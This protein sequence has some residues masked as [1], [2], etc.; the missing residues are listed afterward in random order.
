MGRLL[1]IWGSQAA[2]GGA[3]SP[4]PTSEAPGTAMDGLGAARQN[5][6]NHRNKVGLDK[7]LCTIQCKVLTLG[8]DQLHCAR[9]RGQHLLAHAHDGLVASRPRTLRAAFLQQPALRE[10]CLSGSATRKKLPSKVILPRPNIRG[11]I[12]CCD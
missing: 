11:E 7:I 9:L 10:S 5:G 8:E 1:V 12:E 6:Q 3:Y 4:G 2:G